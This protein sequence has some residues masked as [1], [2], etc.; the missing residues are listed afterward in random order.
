VDQIYALSMKVLSPGLNNR[1]RAYDSAADVF[2]E[3]WVDV[4]MIVDVVVRTRKDSNFLLKWGS[5]WFTSIIKAIR[6][7]HDLGCMAHR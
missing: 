5:H 1:K 3:L 4:D 7:D 2:N 6:A